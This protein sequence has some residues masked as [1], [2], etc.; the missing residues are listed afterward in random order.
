MHV[1]RKSLGPVVT[2]VGLILLAGCG[3]DSS[4]TG[5]GVPPDPP[6]NVA[7][8]GGNTVVTIN[9]DVPTNAPSYNLYWRTSSGVGTGDTN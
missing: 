8:V 4:S 9:W 1:I 5:P 7:A 2:L 6:R 3:S